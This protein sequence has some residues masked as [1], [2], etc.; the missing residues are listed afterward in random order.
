[1][2]SG[3]LEG[4]REFLQGLN[5]LEPGRNLLWVRIG[6]IKNVLRDRNLGVGL[7]SHATTTACT[8]VPGVGQRLVWRISGVKQV[9]LSMLYGTLTTTTAMSVTSG[10]LTEAPDFRIL[11]QVSETANQNNVLKS[12]PCKVSP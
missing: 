2:V 4:F 8:G 7:F 10:C 12:A 6:I 5:G 11:V 1:M 9:S 3:L